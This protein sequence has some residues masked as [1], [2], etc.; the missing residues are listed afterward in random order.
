M[1]RD[2]ITSSSSS[3]SSRYFVRSVLDKLIVALRALC[4]VIVLVFGLVEDHDIAGFCRSGASNATAHPDDA[5]G[6]LKLAEL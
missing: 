4:A 3:S 5:M 6:L 1:S 2:S